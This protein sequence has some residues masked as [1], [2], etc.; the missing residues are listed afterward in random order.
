DPGDSVTHDPHA[1]GGFLTP[2]QST[3]DQVHW[4]PQDLHTPGGL[5]TPDYVNDHVI[6][7]MPDNPHTPGGLS[8]SDLGQLP[9]DTG[10]AGFAVGHAPHDE[11]H[12]E[13][14]LG[15]ADFGPSIMPDVVGHD[16]DP[17]QAPAYDTG[18][19][20]DQSYPSSDDPGA[21]GA[22]FAPDPSH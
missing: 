7:W 1:P 22:I 6:Y 19:G 4:L 12:A 3:G 11:G 5:F 9:H 18:H 8:T 21:S 17:S 13:Y 14:A 10:Q 15:H 2:D 20:P 16:Y